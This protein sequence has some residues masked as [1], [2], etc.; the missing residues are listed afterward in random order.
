MK[1]TT[2]W[3]T[4]VAVGAGLALALGTGG[5]AAS[6]A[7]AP[8]PVS[9]SSSSCSFGQHFVSAWRTVPADLRADLKTARALKPGTERR[10]A[11]KKIQAKALEGGYGPVSEPGPS[12]G[13]ITTA[14]SSVPCQTA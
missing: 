8:A 10:D 13:R 6:A 1:I 7:T 12:G 11:L 9:T 14:R 2:R 5:L 3:A 4:G